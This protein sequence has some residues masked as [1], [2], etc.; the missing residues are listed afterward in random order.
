MSSTECIRELKN[1]AEEAIN[2][3]IKHTFTTEEKQKFNELLNK[4]NTGME[5]EVSIPKKL[6]TNEKR[7]RQPSDQEMF[8]K[9]II[10]TIRTNIKKHQDENRSNIDLKWEL[11]MDF[12]EE[13]TDGK[14]ITLTKIKSRLQDISAQ[15]KIVHK[16]NL[17]TA[18]FRGVAFLLAR[19]YVKGNVKQWFKTE[20]TVPYSTVIKYETFSILVKSFPGLLVCRLRVDQLI[21]H[22]DSILAYLETDCELT[23]SLKTH[24]TIDVQGKD[25]DIKPMTV[26]SLPSSSFKPSIDADQ[27]FEEDSWYGDESLQIGPEVEDQ[28]DVVD[29]VYKEAQD[30]R[31]DVLTRET[32]KNMTLRRK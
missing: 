30:T 2:L 20:F 16:L 32:A 21:K 12:V 28:Q 25:V 23:Y 5:P 9:H 26:D 11:K 18:F 7:Y 29:F 8:N 31:M 6:K 10:P 24:I 27:D 15:E 14:V 13:F 17:L 3:A 1:H 4:L 19:H 22:R